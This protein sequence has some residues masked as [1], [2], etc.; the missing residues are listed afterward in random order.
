MP[1]GLQIW[2][3]QGNQVLDLGD[4]VAIIAGEVNTNGTN[5]SAVITG[6]DE[7]ASLFYISHYFGDDTDE[8]R[9]L[10]VSVSGRTISWQYV[11]TSP[12]QVSNL[13]ARI[14]YGAW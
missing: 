7:S 8:F 2:D 14:I 13:N 3:A 5:G 1:Q 9:E 12:S 4:R 10:R 6:L 11:Q